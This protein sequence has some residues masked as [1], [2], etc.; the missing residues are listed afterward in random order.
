[1]N[2]E[3]IST[4]AGVVVSLLSSFLVQGLAKKTGET[5]GDK[6]GQKAWEMVT[7]LYSSVK[8]KF[9]NKSETQVIITE[10]EKAP[11]N[12]MIQSDFQNHLQTYME[13]DEEFAKQIVQE[14]KL[15]AEA[16]AGT[17]FNTTILGNVTKLVQMG[18]VSVSGDFNI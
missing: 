13:T 1:M 10:F 4:L 8:T 6:A 12:M 5:L 2:P 18:D 11:E 3:A 17:I 14:L 7:K 15:A 9:S 16:G